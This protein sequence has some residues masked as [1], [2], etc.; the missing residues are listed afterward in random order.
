MEKNKDR[1]FQQWAVLSETYGAMHQTWT[2]FLC[3]AVLGGYSLHP[4]LLS[5]HLSINGPKVRQRY[6]FPN[7]ECWS[8]PCQKRREDCKWEYL[9]IIDL[10]LIY[11][12]NKKRI[13]LPNWID[14]WFCMDVSIGFWRWWTVGYIQWISSNSRSWLKRIDNQTLNNARFLIWAAIIF[15]NQPPPWFFELF[16][17]KTLRSWLC[18]YRLFQARIVTYRL[19]HLARTIC[20]S[21]CCNWRKSCLLSQLHPFQLNLG[22]S[23]YSFTFSWWNWSRISIY[24][25]TFLACPKD[26]FLAFPWQCVQTITGEKHKKPCISSHKFDR[27]SIHQV[28]DNILIS[29]ESS[30]I[31]VSWERRIADSFLFKYLGNSG[32]IYIHNH[33][34]WSRMEEQYIKSKLDFGREKKG[35]RWSTSGS[36]ATKHN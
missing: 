23:F 14:D 32:S 12:T 36:K 35:Y 13:L 15:N 1:Y 2:K 9:W 10:M 21:L 29:K 33:I 19:L 25:A 31:K 20:K 22:S 7:F 8:F 17:L 6:D 30:R 27:I 3:S 5:K 26:F 18:F 11:K 4:I 34:V 24:W 28:E 16:I